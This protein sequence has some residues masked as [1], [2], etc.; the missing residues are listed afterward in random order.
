M[1]SIHKLL[2]ILYISL[3]ILTPALA[4]DTGSVSGIVTT[5]DDDPI[6]NAE[7][8]IVNEEDEDFETETD[9]EGA[10]AFDD[11]PIGNWLITGILD[12]LAP[13]EEEIVVVTDEETVVNLILY[14]RP[15]GWTE[16]THGKN[17]DPDYDEIF[18]Q[19]EV[20]RLDIVIDPEDWQMM[21]DDM[22]EKLGE[23]GAGGEGH[24]LERDPNP[25]YRPC[26]ITFNERIWRYAGI[27]FKGNSSLRHSW[28]NGT[29]KLPFR[30]EMDQFEDDYPQIDDQRLYGFKELGLAPGYVDSSLLHE[31]IAADI[32]RDAGV[33]SAQ[34]AFYRVYLD[35]GRGSLYFGL[36]T[37]VEIPRRPMLEAQ[38]GDGR[39]NLYKPGGRGSD[40]VEYHQD[41]FKKKTNKDEADWSDIEAEFE[42]LPASRDD[43]AAWRSGLE[44]VFD[45]YGFL[46]WLA[47]VRLLPNLD[48]YGQH[49]HNY[50]LYGDPTHDGRL[51][52]IP[53]DN[54]MAFTVLRNLSLDMGDLRDNSPLIRY[55]IDDPVYW[56]AYVTNVAEVIE[57]AYAIEPTQASIQAAH[58]LI[59]PYVIGENGERDG[60]TQLTS[61]EVFEN[62]VERLYAHI[63]A[64]HEAAIEFL[65][66]NFDYPE[67]DH[68]AV[69]FELSQNYPN[70]FNSST[71]LVFN[72][73]KSGRIKL[74]IYD[75]YGREIAQLIN[76]VMNAG[77]HTIT[78]DANGLDSGIYFAQLNFNGYSSTQKMV[79]I[80]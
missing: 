78:F 19:D 49:A 43:A 57:G 17:A 74:L 42:A 48:S 35:H 36:Y 52:W 55:L 23:F 11:I 5:V 8:S 33:P 2:I 13:A 69:N 71:T 77:I 4:Q 45:A 41:A 22:T 32:Y 75:I 56:A 73:L 38:F 39:G 1:R 64:R 7:V 67:E 28:A 10:F 59:E 31:K 26:D 62:S 18:P 14:Q 37:I 68:M 44:E 66:S 30:F 6:A 65:E 16:A 51:S 80:N 29:Y 50:F 12:D 34:T 61:P 24:D 60:Y 58:D 47:V 70:P 40:W 79:L 25:I 21:L 3:L 72:I 63:E 15:E 46:R 76:S 54:N 27:R 53:W 9:D 20:N